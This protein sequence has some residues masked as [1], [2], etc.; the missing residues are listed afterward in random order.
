MKNIK[1][2][3]VEN[4]LANNN[5]NQHKQSKGDKHVYDSKRKFKKFK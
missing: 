2:E 1:S 4:L 5:T 3:I